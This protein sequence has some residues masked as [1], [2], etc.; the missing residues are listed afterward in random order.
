[1]FLFLQICPQHN[2]MRK[3]S[4]TSANVLAALLG[5]V[6]VYMCRNVFNTPTVDRRSKSLNVS[7]FPLIKL[8]RWAICAGKTFVDDGCAILAC[9]LPEITTPFPQKTFLF[10]VLASLAPNWRL[11]SKRPSYIS[12]FFEEEGNGCF[13]YV[14]VNLFVYVRYTYNILKLYVYARMMMMIV[15]ELYL[16]RTE[17]LVC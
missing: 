1:M 4:F 6:C 14:Y 13:I 15:S 2:C 8:F 9:S 12:F 16:P 10:V 11:V 5:D 3:K 17:G 7:C